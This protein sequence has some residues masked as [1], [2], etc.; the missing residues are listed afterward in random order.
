MADA[1]LFAWYPGEEGGNAV[2]DIIFGNISPSGRLPVTFYKST[3]DLPPFEDYSMDGRTY[4]YFKG[5]PLYPFGFGLSYSGFSCTEMKTDKE[6]YGNDDTIT[7]SAGLLN[8][9]GSDGE[10]VIQVYVRNVSPAEDDPIKV[11]AGFDR[12]FLKKGESGKIE[13]KIPVKSF[14][15]WNS[16]KHEYITVPGNYFIGTAKNSAEILK[17]AEIV[18]K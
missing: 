15:R 8:E 1:I 7:I 17:E 2:A 14:A 3:S 6:E 4:K 18:I 13:L 5:E 9:G 10:E 11:L 16:E 12:L